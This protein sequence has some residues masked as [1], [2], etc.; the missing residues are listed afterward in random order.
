MQI[1]SLN[2]YRKLF[3]AAV[4]VKQVGTKFL[5]LR[6]GGQSDDLPADSAD[7]ES[8]VFEQEYHW[9]A[10]LQDRNLLAMFSL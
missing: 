8:D 5:N 2:D 3:R 6:S 7:E 9:T 1:V 10:A 4:C